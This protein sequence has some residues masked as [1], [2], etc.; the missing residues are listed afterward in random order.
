MYDVVFGNEEYDPREVVNHSIPDL[1]RATP[2][3]PFF[4][5]LSA[6][7]YLNNRGEVTSK[8]IDSRIIDEAERTLKKF[9]SNMSSSK[10]ETIRNSYGGFKDL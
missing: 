4:K 9:Q 1:I 8:E 10:E 7:G 6:L 5:Y 2:F 3:V